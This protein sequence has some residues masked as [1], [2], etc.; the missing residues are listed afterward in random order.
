MESI[1][2]AKAN[3]LYRTGEYRQALEL[4][5]SLAGQGRSWLQT[6]IELCQRRLALQADGHADLLLAQS[7][8]EPAI[9]ISLTTIH[10][11]LHYLPEVIH[12]LLAQSLQ[13]QRIELNLSHEPYLLDEG[14]ASDHPIV[15][16]LQKL[17]L[18]QINWVTNRG[19][20]R[21]IW[22]LLESWFS[23]SRHGEQLFVTVDDDTLY[24]DYF[25]AQLYHSY[26][27]HDCVVAFRGRHI[28]LQNA[29]VAPYADWTLGRTTPAHHNLPTG[30]DGI[31]YSTRF[32][33]EAFLDYTTAKAL[34]PTADDLWIKWHCALNGVPAVVLNPEASTSDYK[35]FPVVSYAADYRDV[36]LY[37]K[38][39]KDVAGGKNDSSVAGLEQH[40]AGKYG[41]NLATL[42]GRGGATQ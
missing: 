3:T 6:N 14:I 30:K 4:Y 12:S 21:K 1:Q 19:P 34:A 18:V 28:Q 33:T 29:Q 39:N 27:R 25:L 38:F 5:E 32:F 15:L 40:F 26:L 10:S 37:A 36:S 23:G 2:L 17:P 41:Y 9:V 22:P 42:C 31:I 8:P 11:R 24:P 13:P 7:N 35:S 16:E 20:Y